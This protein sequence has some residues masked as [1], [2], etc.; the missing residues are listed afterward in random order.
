MGSL[1]LSS[2]PLDLDKIA[3]AV[4][5]A[6]ENNHGAHWPLAEMD[7]IAGG[8]EAKTDLLVGNQ[9]TVTQRTIDSARKLGITEQD[10]Q[11]WKATRATLDY[12]RNEEMEVSPNKLLR[13]LA[14][15]A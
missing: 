9:E 1:R 4:G 14:E 2:K 6:L 12:W 13:S 10:I 15:E 11:G 7:R 8:I 5:K 3:S